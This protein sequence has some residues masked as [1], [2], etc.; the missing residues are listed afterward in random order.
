MK[1]TRE[2]L[3]DLIIKN[4]SPYIIP[5]LV[6]I[7]GDLDIILGTI[8][9]ASGISRAAIISNSRKTEIVA[10]RQAYCYYARKYT[11]KSFDRIGR[12]INRDHATV[13]HSVRTVNDLLDAKDSMMLDLVNKVNKYL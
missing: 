1:T 9:R 4:L 13:L 12:D 6:H 2:K 7:P 10:A 3:T 11:K 8:C 5:G